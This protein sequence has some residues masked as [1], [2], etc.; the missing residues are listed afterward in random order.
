MYSPSGLKSAMPIGAVRNAASKCR[1]ARA[2]IEAGGGSRSVQS[3]PP[4]VRPRLASTAN[5][6]PS[7]RRPTPR[8][9]APSS[10]DTVTSSAN[11]RPTTSPRNI[12]PAFALAARTRSSGPIHSAASGTSSNVDL[13]TSCDDDPRDGPGGGWAGLIGAV[14]MLD[15]PRPG[16]R[17]DRWSCRPPGARP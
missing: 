14:I 1:W 6:T 7:R 12:A 10:A 15:H 9:D 11:G 5:G 3:A 2:G 13:M 4:A 8:P 17:F 16:K